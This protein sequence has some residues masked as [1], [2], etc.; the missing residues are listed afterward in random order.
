MNIEQS[1]RALRRHTG[2]IYKYFHGVVIGRR[3]R[4][5]RRRRWPN[6][7]FGSLCFIFNR[8]LK[9]SAI[10]LHFLLRCLWYLLLLV[11]VVVLYFITFFFRSSTRLN[12]YLVH[13][14]KMLFCFGIC[15]FLLLLFQQVF[16]RASVYD[17]FYAYTIV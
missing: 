1:P 5:H 2:E 11:V 7:Q 12:T 17:I 3:H 14:T 8:Y 10:Y 13:H 16:R 9:S 6:Q 4:R 15:F